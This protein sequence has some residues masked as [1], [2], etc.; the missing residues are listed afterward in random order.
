MRHE[1]HQKQSLDLKIRIRDSNDVAVDLSGFPVEF[2]VK[3]PDGVVSFPCTHDPVTNIIS[4][5]VDR[6]VTANWLP[7]TYPFQFWADFGENTAPLEN[8]VLYKERLTV[9]EGL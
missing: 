5:S 8:D 1:V 7:G 4:A 6:D 9:L 2:R 3:F